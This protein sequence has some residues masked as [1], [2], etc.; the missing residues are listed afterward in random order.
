MCLLFDE[1]KGERCQAKYLLSSGIMSETMG[2]LSQSLGKRE[3]VPGKNTTRI[4]LINP[5]FDIRIS[6]LLVLS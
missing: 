1:W 2:T 3:E 6:D 5:D 4:R